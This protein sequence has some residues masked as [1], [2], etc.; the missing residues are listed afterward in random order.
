[1]VIDIEGVS[2]YI[3]DGKNSGI[4]LSKSLMEKIANNILKIHII[5]LENDIN[6]STKRNM[7]K[8]S[9]KINVSILSEEELLD[10]IYSKDLRYSEYKNDKRFVFYNDLEKELRSIAVGVSNF[11]IVRNIE[12]INDEDCS[13]YYEHN[14]Y[15]FISDNYLQLG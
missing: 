14:Y 8:I 3:H 12:L 9:K 15:R 6:D 7:K 1:M 5:I 13:Y 10:R 4:R 11:L 2:L